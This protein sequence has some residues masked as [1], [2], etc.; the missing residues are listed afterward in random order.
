MTSD[1]FRWWPLATA[2]VLLAGLSIEGPAGAAP[3]DLDAALGGFEAQADHVSSPS[4]D[5]VVMDGNVTFK[6]GAILL[7]ADHMRFNRTTRAGE[8]T[9][10]VLY[11]QPG[12]RIT[13]EHVTF[14]L[15]DETAEITDAAGYLDEG[16]LFR[17]RRV[18]QLDAR[19]MRFESGVFTACTQPVPYWSFHVHR[20]LIVKDRY[21]HLRNLT[22]EA[23]KVPV[24]WAPYLL[25]PIKPD[26][27]TGMLMPQIAFSDR[28]GTS[29]SNAFFWAI[30]RNQDATF[31]LDVYNQGSVGGGAEYRFV[32]S[33]RGA[34]QFEGF[35][36]DEDGIDDASDPPRQ[37][38]NLRYRQRQE[39]SRGRRFLA[40]L[41]FV[42]DGDYFLDFSRDLDR[43]SDP[44]A[45]SR[46]E[47][48]INRG[49]ASWN[50]RVDRREQFFSGADIIQARL[51]EIEL[52][53]R[54]RRLG[55]SPF[56]LA[57][58]GSGSLLDKSSAV[59][60]DG[61]YGRL[62]LFPTL[63]APISPLPFLDI[64]PTLR[65]R[66]TYY[67]RSLTPVDP[68]RIAPPPPQFDD[69][70]SREF[71]QF[72]LQILG[73]RLARVFRDEEGNGRHKSTIEPQLAYRY[74][75]TPGSLDPTRVPRFDEIDVLPGDVNQVR[76]GVVTRIQS[77][78]VIRATPRAPTR[79]GPSWLGDFSAD[80]GLADEDEGVFPAGER[81]Q[82]NTEKGDGEEDAAGEMLS[83]PVEVASFFISQQLSL[84]NDL[85]F[86][87]E[88]LDT[89]GDGIEENVVVDSSRFSPVTIGGRYNPSPGSSVDVTLRY[90]VLENAV[91]STSLSAS[92]F[93]PRHGFLNGTW[94][95]RNG[96]DGRTL[97]ASTLRV[98][99][100]TSFLGDRLSMAV[101]VNYDATL[102]QFQDQRY[103]LGYD[104]QC[105]GFAVEI[106][107]RDFIGTSQNEF[108]FVVNLRGLGNFLDLQGR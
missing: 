41:E 71:L 42:S 36:I 51:P 23:G 47:Y 95:F 18:E 2:L 3:G 88:F 17:A 20:G 46:A 67:T 7:Q 93:G 89:D 84:D 49:Y 33:Q 78:R 100:G 81:G 83:S 13:S 75:T 12:I 45:L 87:R 104:T 63:S 101:A 30:R 15:A 31:F 4:A 57:F 99:G 52:R 56:F 32:P 92:L 38:W 21:V 6:S 35:F 69:G 98:A 1:R 65:L 94:F 103:R 37:R 70:L 59:L 39:F 26:R 14:N 74:Q 107:Q 55:K 54:S 25:F 43:G 24:F 60:P 90:D 77:R 64:T 8:A 76:Y 53:T 22:L 10:N 28:L 97:N 91:S 50:F 58:E 9:G 62:D 44:A 29:L 80:R 40:N 61:S 48:A 105:C 73:P 19:R 106:R 27:A 85:S 16:F 86:E 34:G 72:D 102:D 108:R 66:E 11:V 5:E 79:R 82:K 68:T 96:L